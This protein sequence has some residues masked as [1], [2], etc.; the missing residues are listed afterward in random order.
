MRPVLV[1]DAKPEPP[2]VPIVVDRRQ[3]GTEAANGLPPTPEQVHAEGG[4]RGTH[5]VETP[6]TILPASPPLLLEC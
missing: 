6:F 1:G 5:A 2:S 3:S 4:V